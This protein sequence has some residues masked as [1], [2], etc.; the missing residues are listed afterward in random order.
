MPIKGSGEERSDGPEGRRLTV[1]STEER[2]DANVLHD[3]GALRQLL[4]QGW[5]VDLTIDDLHAELRA[6]QS[7][8]ARR[9]LVVTELRASLVPSGQGVPSACDQLL[10]VL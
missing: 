4:Q 6:H 1:I 10:T 2:V 8:I 7:R 9:L 3:S 5:P